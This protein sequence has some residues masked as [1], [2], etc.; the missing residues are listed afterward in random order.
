MREKIKKFLNHKILDIRIA[1]MLITFGIFSLVVLAILFPK[2][3]APVVFMLLGAILFLVISIFV[4]GAIDDI[5]SGK[6]G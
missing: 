1:S 5:M 3:S 6:Y 2:A 4:D